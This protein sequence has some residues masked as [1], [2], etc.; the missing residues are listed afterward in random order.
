M[1]TFKKK[2]HLIFPKFF[3]SIFFWGGMGMGKNC[4]FFEKKFLLIFFQNFSSICFCG[5]GKRG[6][7]PGIFLKKKSENKFCPYYFSEIK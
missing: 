2:F 4:N 7:C 5:G 3:L 1:N 6:G